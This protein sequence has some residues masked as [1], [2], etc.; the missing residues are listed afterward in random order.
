M[1]P[2]HRSGITAILLT[3]YLVIGLAAN[4]CFKEGGTDAAHRLVYFIGGNVLG[5][6]STALLMGVYG[7]MNV[8]LA[9]VLATSGAFLLMQV[10]FW[11]A[12]HTQL[13][14]MQIAGILMV[15]AGTVLA[16]MRPAARTGG[17]ER[18]LAPGTVPVEDQQ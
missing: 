2:K 11:L 10:S 15:G 8:N 4:F 6:T 5:I 17:S 14:A 16:S 18:V 9:M 1:N 7:R 12:Y 13:T 3:G